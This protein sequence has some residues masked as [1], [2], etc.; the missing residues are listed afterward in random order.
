MEGPI[1]FNVKRIEG[2]GN[3]CSKSDTFPVAKGGI[4]LDSSLF[5][6]FEAFL[7]IKIKIVRTFQKV[8]LNQFKFK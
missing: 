3:T 6:D 5:Q 7:I 8:K 2:E 1:F 4:I